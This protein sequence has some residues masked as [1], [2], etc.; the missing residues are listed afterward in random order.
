MSGTCHILRSTP[1]PV[2]AQQM[3]RLSTGNHQSPD[4]SLRIGPGRTKTETNE[5]AA[6]LAL[7]RYGLA[8]QAGVIDRS[9]GPLLAL[10]VMAARTGLSGD[11][12]ASVVRAMSEALATHGHQQA[13]RELLEGA[14]GGFVVGGDHQAAADLAELLVLASYRA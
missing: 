13:S 12:V 3:A 10:S 2:E 5:I 8:A 4:L 1:E 9:L 14:I 7:H 11:E 6:I